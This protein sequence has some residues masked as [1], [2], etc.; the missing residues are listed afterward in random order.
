MEQGR[1]TI[2]IEN[3]SKI[4]VTDGGK[5][6]NVA[7]TSQEGDKID[8]T[9]NTTNGKEDESSI[10]EASTT[11]LTPATSTSSPAVEWAKKNLFSRFDV[12][13][14]IDLIIYNQN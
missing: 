9:I 5:Y 10:N 3:P 13:R 12:S 2:I 8:A 14:L 7:V 11:T 4:V 6:A 1:G